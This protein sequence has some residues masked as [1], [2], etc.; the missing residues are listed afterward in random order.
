MKHICTPFREKCSI[1]CS[2]A[3]QVRGDGD[4]NV[5]RLADCDRLKQLG[6]MKQKPSCLTFRTRRHSRQTPAIVLLWLRLM[7]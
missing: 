5:A 7:Q 1:R 4:G 2:P 3:I 6:L